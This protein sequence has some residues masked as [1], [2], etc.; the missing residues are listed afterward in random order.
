MTGPIKMN[1]N[2]GTATMRMDDFPLVLYVLRS[3][4]IPQLPSGVTATLVLSGGKGVEANGTF[5]GSRLS[6]KDITFRIR[7]A[8]GELT[9]EQV[10]QGMSALVDFEIPNLEIE[11]IKPFNQGAITLHLDT[12]L[13]Q[14]PSGN[15]LFDQFLSG[16][17]VI[18]I[19]EGELAM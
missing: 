11:T 6:I 19:L 17:E 4:D 2:D 9:I 18:A 16:A 1:I 5:D 10:K 15:E 3:S 13:P 12:K 7:V 14:N 8:L